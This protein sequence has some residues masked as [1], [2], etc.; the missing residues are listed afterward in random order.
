MDDWMI[1]D[2]WRIGKC[3]DVIGIEYI[4]QM[5]QNINFNVSNLFIYVSQTH[6]REVC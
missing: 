4:S 5:I 6:C 2:I 3:C 1:N